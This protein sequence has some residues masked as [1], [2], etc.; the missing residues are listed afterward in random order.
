VGLP[1]ELVEHSLNVTK[2]AKP[3]K[4]P[5]L[6]FAEDRRKIVG[7]EVTKL[8]VAG[9]IAEVLH[10]E[11]LANPILVEKKEE[12]PKKKKEVGRVVS[13]EIPAGVYRNKRYR[14]VLSWMSRG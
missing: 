13:S 3:V 14:H 1:K 8:L 5:L 9:F 2:D 4:Q 6:C 10:T 11:W 7:V 12:D